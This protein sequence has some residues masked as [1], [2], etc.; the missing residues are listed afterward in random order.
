MLTITD[1]G[2]PVSSFLAAAGLNAYRLRWSDEAE[3]TPYPVM[4]TSGFA[5]EGDPA[6][7]TGAQEQTWQYQA[8]VPMPE[9][10]RLA[11]IVGSP[12]ETLIAR[13]AV[14]QAKEPGRD[15]VNVEV[16]RDPLTNGAFWVL[17]LQ[18]PGVI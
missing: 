8:L 6:T 2:S 7:R 15:W 12:V 16:V 18:I 5:A 17:V 13:K 3:V 9:M 4:S 10:D 1:L 14:W 11:A